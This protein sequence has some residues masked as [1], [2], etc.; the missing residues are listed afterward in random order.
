M[1]H[2][3]NQIINNMIIRNWFQRRELNYDL[4]CIL[5]KYFNPILYL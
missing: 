1:N 2:P 4:R 3:Y 5:F